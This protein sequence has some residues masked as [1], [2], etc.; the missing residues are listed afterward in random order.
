MELSN[1]SI[2]GTRDCPTSSCDEH[3]D[4]FCDVVTHSPWDARYFKPNAR[5]YTHSGYHAAAQDPG[6]GPVRNTMFNKITK[7]MENIRGHLSPRSRPSS[8]SSSPTETSFS[9]NTSLFQVD[10]INSPMSFTAGNTAFNSQESNASSKQHMLAFMGKIDTQLPSAPRYDMYGVQSALTSTT[11]PS[12]YG[13]ESWTPFSSQASSLVSPLS[14]TMVSP[15]WECRL[16][17][18]SGPDLFAASTTPC[19]AHPYPYSPLSYHSNTYDLQGHANPQNEFSF[20]QGIASI[21]QGGVNTEARMSGF[22][23]DSNINV[24]FKTILKD[25]D[26]EDDNSWAYPEPLFS[27]ANIPPPQEFCDGLEVVPAEG[28]EVVPDDGPEVVTA[29]GAAHNDHADPGR[30]SP[31][32]FSEISMAEVSMASDASV[33][34]ISSPSPTPT[35]ADQLSNSQP[36]PK[37]RVCGWSPDANAGHRSFAKLRAAV[38]KHFKR[39]HQGQD[40]PC[41]A[42]PQYFRNRPDNV[43]PHI[44]RKHPELFKRLY[45]HKKKKTSAVSMVSTHDG[46]SSSSSTCESWAGSIVEASVGKPATTKRGGRNARSQRG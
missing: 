40:H 17:H 20:S 31:N 30:I 12:S 16:S 2:G 26:D 3:F 42:C 38:E 5:Q 28:L 39:N 23:F 4:T 15:S 35:A 25:L 44:R 13:N 10:D 43:K 29:Y 24:D 18:S 19:D 11:T 1:T 14:Q 33:S 46:S 21:Q 9:Y 41:P 27:N 37:C 32:S 36:S 8:H 34:P 7:S 45:Q 22:V 6:V